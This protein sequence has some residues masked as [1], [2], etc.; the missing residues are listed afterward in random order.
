MERRVQLQNSKQKSE[1]HNEENVASGNMTESIQSGSATVGNQ[2]AT[3]TQSK[4]SMSSSPNLPEPSFTNC[5]IPPK[6]EEVPRKRIK[7][8]LP[9]RTKPC[10]SPPAKR[11][12]MTKSMEPEEDQIPAALP[13]E[14]ILDDLI[15]QAVKEGAIINLTDTNVPSDH[16]IEAKVILE[17]CPMPITVAI[18]DEEPATTG[19]EGITNVLEAPIHPE[20]RRIQEYLAQRPSVRESAHLKKEVILTTEQPYLTHVG[21]SLSQPEILTN[22]AQVEVNQS[23]AASSFTNY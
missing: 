22:E 16:I 23:N 14:N 17:P 18:A 12:R 11:R 20:H 3:R 8:L 7:T 9:V 5:E 21:E 13:E 10:P 4:V 2:I 6:V 1:I 19:S 15:N